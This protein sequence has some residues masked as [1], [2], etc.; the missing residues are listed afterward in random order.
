MSAHERT[1]WRDESIS[2]RHREWGYNCPA[3]D[4]DFLVAEY[5]LGKPVALIE[6][7]HERARWPDLQH[8]TYRALRELADVADLP[9]AVVFYRQNPWRFLVLPANEKA[10]DFYQGQ[11]SLSELRFVRSLYVLRERVVDASV[12]PLLSDLEDPLSSWPA[13]E[14][15]AV[16]A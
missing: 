6:Y 5:N 8:A 1:G 16:A 4:L 11:R 9:F 12:E 3:V 2:R 10:Q 7:K 13:A 14:I 15:K